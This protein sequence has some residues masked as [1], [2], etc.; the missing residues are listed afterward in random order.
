[1]K[2]Q[3]IIL[4]SNPFGYGPTTTLIHIAEELL[5]RTDVELIV[6]GK[7]DGLCREIFKNST[8]DIPWQDVN[9]RDIGEIKRFLSSQENCAVISILNRFSI[10]VANEL[11]IPCVLID[12]LA[13]FWEK[14]AQEYGYADIYFT[15]YLGREIRQI[16]NHTID[17]PIILGPIPQRNEEDI[18]LINIGG[19]QNPLVEGIPVNY[20][21][22]F[23]KI[24]NGLNFKGSKVFIAGGI[25]ATDFI[26][27]QISDSSYNIASYQHKDFL[28]LHAKAKRFI[29]LSGT[30]ATFMSFA[31]DI[32]TIFLLPQLLAHWKLSIL[33]KEMGIKDILMWEDY[34]QISNDQYHCS[35]KETV[36]F[37]EDL[38]TKTMAD[39]GKMTDLI[40][41]IQTWLEISPNTST[42]KEF[43]RKIGVG[44]EKEVVSILIDRW[45]L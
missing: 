27:S 44:G 8:K 21:T 6:A 9:E 23:S 12:F 42:Q 33:L 28:N 17:V 10:Q 4:F 18:I 32:P 25:K 1:M 43:I 13:W 22:L 30:N 41:K 36:P 45:E 34:Y 2:V 37:T 31:L 20:L 16:N 19:S 5:K 35:E 26:R 7:E 3:K 39:S 24:I 40:G 14:P 29:S 15:N 38:S 11:G